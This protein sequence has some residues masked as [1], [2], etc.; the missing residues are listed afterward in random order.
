MKIRSKIVIGSTILL[1]LG[2]ITWIGLQW[3]TPNYQL[4][5]VSA[6]RVPQLS[7]P[8]DK[9]T[10]GIDDL[11]E[12]VLGAKKEITRKPVYRSAYYSEDIRLKQKEYAPM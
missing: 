11:T 7:C 12:Y 6:V 8:V 10:D 3:L 1:P 4:P 9:D 2:V 5:F